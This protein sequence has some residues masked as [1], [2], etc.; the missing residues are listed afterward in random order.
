MAGLRKGHALRSQKLTSSS[1]CCRE[2]KAKPLVVGN[3]DPANHYV[4]LPWLVLQ[5]FQFAA[6]ASPHLA[7]FS[8]YKAEEAVK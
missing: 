5:Q 6:G 8:R 3:A 1:R 7:H 4:R 2:R